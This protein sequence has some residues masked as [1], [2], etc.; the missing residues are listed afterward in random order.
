VGSYGTVIYTN[1]AGYTWNESN[2]GSEVDLYDVHFI[3]NSTGF[4][5]GVTYVGPHLY[6]TVYKT[7]DGGQNWKISFQSESPMVLNSMTF[8]DTHNGFLTGYIYGQGGT[9]GIIIKTSDAGLNWEIVSA[10]LGIVDID[11]I[12]FNND[13]DIKAMMIGWATGRMNVGPDE[14]SVILKSVDLGNSWNVAY[15]NSKV[16][17]FSD[18]SFLDYFN[19]I[20]VGENG[21]VLTTN[22]AGNTWIAQKS[23]LNYL[24]AALMGEDDFICIVGDN[25]AI[26][27]T[28]G[29]NYNWV[30]EVIPNNSNLTSICSTPVGYVWI[31]GYDGTLLRKPN[32]GNG[33]N[34]NLGNSSAAGELKHTLTENTTEKNT[35]PLVSHTNY[36]NP[37]HSKTTISFEI[38]K[39]NHVKL[40]IYNLN[41]KLIATLKDQVLDSGNYDVIFN[42]NDLPP[43]I[44]TYTLRAGDQVEY[45]KMIK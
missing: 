31:A 19:G 33:E 11:N 41:G 10:Y 29:N 38:D 3:D 37:F 30:Q 28:T 14:V 7:V 23:A 8:A 42:P 34:Q 9:N 21:M 36:P 27:S 40:D 12:V 18:I 1:D 2:I 5:A 20:A 45:G 24:N 6:G 16:T 35:E 22:N 43:G 15:T 17:N 26:I 25:G 4:A 44:Y 32:L 39:Q 13:D